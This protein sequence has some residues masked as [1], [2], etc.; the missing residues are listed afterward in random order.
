MPRG[1][2]PAIDA[3]RTHDVAEG[4]EEILGPGYDLVHTKRLGWMLRKWDTWVR[5][6]GLPRDGW[7]EVDSAPEGQLGALLMRHQRRERGQLGGR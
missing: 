7:R 4:L 1:R 5:A 6:D 2:L 3:T